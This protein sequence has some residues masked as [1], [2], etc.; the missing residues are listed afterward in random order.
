[1][2]GL[3][4]KGVAVGLVSCVSGRWLWF[5]QETEAVGEEKGGAL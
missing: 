2:F 5:G 4:K 3:R 1:V